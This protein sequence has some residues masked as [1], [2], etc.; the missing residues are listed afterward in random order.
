[1]LPIG[2]Y[3]YVE[4]VF[5]ILLGYSRTFMN[6]FRFIL[7]VLRLEGGGIDGDGLPKFIYLLLIIIK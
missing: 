7:D 5:A 6:N 3:M 2:E 1:M 4:K